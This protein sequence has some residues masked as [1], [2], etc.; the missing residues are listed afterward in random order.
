MTYFISMSTSFTRSDSR[1]R[2]SVALPNTLQTEY[3]KGVKQ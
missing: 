1:G 3:V 2:Q